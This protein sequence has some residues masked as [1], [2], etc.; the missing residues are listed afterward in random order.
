M[1]IFLLNRLYNIRVVWTFGSVLATKKVK[2][3]LIN[4]FC[5]FSNR[6]KIIIKER[7]KSVKVHNTQS[8]KKQID[9]KLQSNERKSQHTRSF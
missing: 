1:K 3:T 6:K 2:L 4:N 7:S 8:N 5:V 9:D